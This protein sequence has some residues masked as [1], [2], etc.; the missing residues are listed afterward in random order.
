MKYLLMNKDNV[1]GEFE[2]IQKQLGVKAVVNETLNKDI[3]NV[4]SSVG[5]W[6]K[7]RKVPKNR[8][9]I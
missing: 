1:I 7:T 3:S 6:L 8:E 5:N 2:F 4:S 9:F